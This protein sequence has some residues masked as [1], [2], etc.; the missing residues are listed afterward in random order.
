VLT[1]G[2]RVLL[3]T[4][5]AAALAA[6]PAVAAPAGTTH[7]PDLQTVIPT[8][9]FSVVTNN[10]AR[11]FRYTHLVYNAGPGPLE[12]QPS[13]SQASGAYQG[14][15]L[16]F[17]HDAAGHWSQVGQVRVPDAF[18]FHAEHGHF[19]FPLA[20]FGLYQV[21]P[22]GG[23]GAP[24]VMSP[25]NGF[26]I[27]DSSIYSTTVEHSGVFVG[28]QGSCADPTTLRGLSVGAV[29]EYD[30]RDPGQAIPF[31]G[32]PD[33]TYW[34]KAVTDPNND[35]VEANEANNE[36]DVKVTV[37][38][39]VVT[40]GEVRH[41]DT[42]P[43]QLSMT[44]PADGTTVTGAVPM[45]ATTPVIGAGSVQ[46]V[47]DGNVVGTSTDTASPY[48][49]SWD[50]T[51]VVDGV[52]WLAARVTDANGR[53]NT[54]SVAA[55][56]VQNAAAQPPPPPGVL[57]LD[58]TQSA[59]GRGT[60]TTPPLSTTQGGDVLL[61]FVSSDGPPGPGAQTSTVSGGGLAWSLVRRQNTSSGTAE[62]WK[63]GAPTSLSGVGVTSTPA[64]PGYDQS[65]SVFAFANASGV[66]VTGGVSAA[67]GAPS[68]SLVTTAQGSWVW[69]V[70]N[71]YDTATARAL[72][73]GQ[74]M[75]HQWVDTGTGDTFWTQSQT[76]VTAA[77]GTTVPISDIGPTGDQWNLA[78]VEVKAGTG[79]P[80]P[81]PPQ[82]TSPPKVTVTDPQAGATVGGTVALGAT[83][84]DDVGV[85][86]LQ[87]KVDGTPVGAPI[88]TPPFMLQW[89]SR[90]VSAGQH[91]ISAEARDAAGNV[92][93]SAGVVVTVDNS[94][95]PPA[96]IGIDTAQFVH[97]R[98]TLR[99]PGLTTPT[100]G[101]ELVAFV[102][103]DGPNAA[104]QQR[105]TL[106]G[107][108]LTWTLVKR[109]DSQAGVA[110]I[111][112]AKPTGTL[113]S[114]AITA[115]PLKS[116]YDGLLDVIAFR[117]ARDVGIAGASGAASGPPDIYLPGIGTGS[118]VFAVGNDWDRAVARTPVAGQTLQHQWVD[119]GIGDTYWVQSTA[120]P[121]TA[122][123]LVT[124]HD[125]AP[126]ND[127]WN[128]AAVEV[129]P[130]PG[131]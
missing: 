26:C 100:A 6:A 42:T 87:F 27:A 47:V 63:A 48:R 4:A 121:N 80:P 37:A 61:C 2:I 124:I 116:G 83:A 77:S 123:G 17:T 22:D 23:V 105:A 58:G 126:T 102:A 101:D 43:P 64:Q 114:Q 19:H 122:M 28:T 91:T 86:S 129:L 93:S 110:E 49:F 76:A 95:P 14:Q 112:S 104:Q 111:W 20:S 92:G 59:D 7:Y 60:V 68:A 131:G 21:A 88:T 79:T 50:S 84:A 57:G 108:G 75:R 29:D 69:G 66:G 81:P 82:D 56:N 128:Y 71:D 74:T 125:N 32:V 1:T 94:A 97:A 10:G 34:F 39:G 119:T 72:P 106:T 65:V 24:I 53:I 62:I 8:D 38:N 127:R 98:G 45:S 44:A 85:T 78:T 51:T 117:N 89:D 18:V 3:A 73:A 55:V 40:P 115:T 35:I 52:H 54:S 5:A 70:G 120:A 30:Y 36:T 113:T 31:D 67:S 90:T 46:F 118:W 13:Y 109:S 130:T 107:G 15:Q 41:P 96:T 12:I 99:T 9:S 103:M 11:E 33:G 16:L 25:K